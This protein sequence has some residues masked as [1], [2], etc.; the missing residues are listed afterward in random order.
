MAWGK[1]GTVPGGRRAKLP[2]GEGNSGLG[3]GGGEKGTV[4]GGKKGTVAWGIE[5]KSSLSD[6][7]SGSCSRG[8]G[9]A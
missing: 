7:Q 3:G 8:D 5:K 4:V 2:E 9:S 1:K 6:H